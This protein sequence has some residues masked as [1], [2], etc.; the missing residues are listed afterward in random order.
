[1]AIRLDLNSIHMIVVV[2]VRS[3]Q[4][5]RLI[6]EQASERIP[7]AVAETV[8]E[9]PNSNEHLG[10]SSSPRTSP[11]CN[12]REKKD[13]RDLR[14]VE[15]SLHGQDIS[16]GRAHAERARI[17][18]IDES[19]ARQDPATSIAAAISDLFVWREHHVDRRTKIE[20]ASGNTTLCLHPRCDDAPLQASGRRRRIASRSRHEL[21]S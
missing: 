16:A 5:V 4:Q 10:A 14:R 2:L 20:V 3:R 12:R 21:V 19:Q 7:N 11:Q 15:I 8:L 1:M 17:V 18:G 9:S 6:R 13:H